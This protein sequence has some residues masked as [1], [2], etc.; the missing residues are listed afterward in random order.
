MFTIVT[1][2][3][4][5]G[6]VVHHRRDH[7]VIVHS[8]LESS[9]LWFSVRMKQDFTQQG[10]APPF[11][12]RGGCTPLSPPEGAAPPF[13]PQ[14]GLHPPFTPAQPKSIRTRVDLNRSNNPDPNCRT[15]T[16]TFQSK[17]GYGGATP[18]C[19]GLRGVQPPFFR[20]DGTL[21]DVGATLSSFARKSKTLLNVEITLTKLLE[22]AHHFEKVCLV[23]DV[24][25]G[26]SWLNEMDVGAAHGRKSF[27]K[28]FRF[29]IPWVHQVRR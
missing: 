25:V 10:A 21:E 7:F 19:G 6:N 20:G 24:T 4:D 12:P 27:V 17:R 22:Y 14:R 16:N 3:F 8:N 5:V 23:A 1:G 29:V 13:H 26:A 11:T 2:C 9:E 15:D 28:T 18:I